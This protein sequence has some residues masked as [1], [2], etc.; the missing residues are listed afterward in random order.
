MKGLVLRKTAGR[1][2]DTPPLVDAT[3]QAQDCVFLCTG[4]TNDLWAD[5]TNRNHRRLPR[6][7]ISFFFLK[8]VSK[9][10]PINLA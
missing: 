1:S 4:M 8:D 2:L 6:D 10:P 9:S 5:Q 3:P 7:A